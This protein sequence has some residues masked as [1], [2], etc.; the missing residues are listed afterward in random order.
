ME[1]NLRSSKPNYAQDMTGA[2]EKA[3]LK[4][5]VLQTIGSFGGY[6]AKR[7]SPDDFNG[8]KLDQK[9]I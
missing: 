4:K 1:T 5:L 9:V 8:Q 7:F 3:G 2:R 6:P